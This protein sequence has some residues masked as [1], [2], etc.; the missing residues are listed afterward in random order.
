M[1]KRGSKNCHFGRYSTRSKQ[2]DKDR[3]LL[4]I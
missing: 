3:S 2:L 4:D 1:R